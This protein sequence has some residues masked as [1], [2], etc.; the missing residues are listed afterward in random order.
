[1]EGQNSKLSY[2]IQGRAEEHIDLKKSI[3]LVALI[4]IVRMQQTISIKQRQEAM[5]QIRFF[6]HGT[7][8][9]S[10]VNIFK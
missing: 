2:S 5:K 9:L 7:N 6:S 1:M 3:R 4:I 8:L 10:A